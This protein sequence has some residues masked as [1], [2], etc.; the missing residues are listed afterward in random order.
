MVLKIQKD[1]QRFRKIVKGKIRGDLR[2]FLTQ[3]E[4]LGKEGRRLVSIPV[5]GVQIPQFR[6]GDNNNEG[7]G[8]GDAEPGEQV[9]GE[10]QGVGPG[11]T[12]PGRHILEVDVSLEELADILGEELELPRI[13]PRGK[14][15]ITSERDKY[16][17]I[18]PVGPDS[19]RH[20]RR[21]YREALK[22]QIASGI[23]DKN[24]PVVIPIRR[25]QR[26]RSWKTVLKPHSNAVIIYI[27]D[28]S[29][30][31]GAEQKELVRYEAFWIDAWLR[32]NYEGIESRYL[33]HDVGAKE[34]DRDTFF[35]LRE[36][37]G[38][39][40]SSAIRLCRDL[41]D[42]TYRPDEWNIYCFQFS[43]GDNSS[44]ADSRECVNMLSDVLLDSMNLYGYCQVASAYGSGAFHKV[45]SDR[46][47]ETE[48][49]EL[50]K[51]NSRDDILDSIKSFFRKGR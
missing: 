17:G 43:D 46:L 47:K 9:D 42:S 29:G 6:Y 19:L 45:L 48:N 32:R 37:G 51:V 44:E 41:I 1:H 7:V 21:T 27:M 14:H 35:R 11:G 24:D 16:S 8:I 10:G 33:V 40:I 39:K 34:V 12:T 2:K 22:R 26:F 4:L 18:R 30:S 13:R 49:V 28:V 3:G 38:T 36:D 15:T 50:T 5:H 25:D 31:M 23:Y 20:F